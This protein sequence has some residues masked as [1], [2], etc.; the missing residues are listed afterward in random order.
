MT[1]CVWCHGKGKLSRMSLLDNNAP[2]RIV[3]CS[4]CNGTGQESTGGT[5][6]IATMET[7]LRDY[8]SDPQYASCRI[9]TVNVG[10]GAVF[11]IRTQAGAEHFFSVVD[12]TTPEGSHYYG[13]VSQLMDTF[14]ELRRVE[15][16]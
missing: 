4:F 11:I 1:E 2:E 16:L 7:T 3:D 9:A 13:T 10:E 15:L 8:L 5:W 14:G 6:P 12:C